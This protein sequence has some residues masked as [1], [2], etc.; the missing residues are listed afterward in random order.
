M[1][2]RKVGA[3]L[4]FSILKDAQELLRIKQQHL[5]GYGEEWLDNVSA[6][7]LGTENVTNQEDEL[8]KA[9]EDKYD[10]LRDKLLM[11]ALMKQFSEAEWARM[12]DKE[13]QALLTKLKLQE[14]RL[15]QQGKFDEAARLLGDA[16]KD[17]DVLQVSV[18]S[19]FY[20]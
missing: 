19:V 17:A 2:G 14:K 10:S 8:V 5:Q 4:F 12:S 16:F 18:L 11:Q 3:L 7:L 13:R 15:R 9:L 20:D 6:V 1:L